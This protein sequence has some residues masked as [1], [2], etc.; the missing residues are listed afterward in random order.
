M[1]LTWGQGFAREQAICLSC[2]LVAWP[3]SHC[4]L[5]H[6]IALGH[7]ASSHLDPAGAP[8]SLP[9]SL[10]H[11][12][13]HTH[14]VDPPPPPGTPPPPAPP[15]LHL[16]ATISAAQFAALCSAPPLQGAAWRGPRPFQPLDMQ[17]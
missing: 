4:S 1:G 7:T 11:T 16:P 9:P 5:H 3:V 8:A 13:T 17:R 10:L 14:Q 6:L 12:H 15:P 2:M